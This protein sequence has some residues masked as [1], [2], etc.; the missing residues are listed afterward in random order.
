MT[1]ADSITRN[2]L[3]RL[4]RAYRQAEALK[5]LPGPARYIEAYGWLASAVEML[6]KEFEVEVPQQEKSD[7]T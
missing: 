1:H 7:E 4:A 3:V 2:R 5:R 6:L